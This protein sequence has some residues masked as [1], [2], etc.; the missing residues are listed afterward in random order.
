MIF[1]GFEDENKKIVMSV[2]IISYIHC[3]QKKH[4]SADPN[5]THK[6]KLLIQCKT[7]FYL[8]NIHITI[9]YICFGINN[10]NINLQY[11]VLS[12]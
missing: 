8:S 7:K 10:I 2:Y 5:E 1:I 4:F 9:T 11:Y 6:K 12:E 3:H